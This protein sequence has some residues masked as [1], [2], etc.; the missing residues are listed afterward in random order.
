MALL[1]FLL[2]PPTLNNSSSKISGVFSGSFDAEKSSFSTE[3]SSLTRRKFLCEGMSFNS[4]AAFSNWLAAKISLYCSTGAKEVMAPHDYER[5]CR[6]ARPV[7]GG[8]PAKSCSSC[9]HGRNLLMTILARLG[10]RGRLYGNFGV[11]TPLL[12]ARR[13]GF[14]AKTQSAS[15]E[16]IG[17]SFL[18]EKGT[19]FVELA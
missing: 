1:K 15:M 6:F 11:K 16:Q 10:V 2:R 9:I 5:P 19:Q 3:W 18:R 17:W 8:V 7:T 4:C 14:S 13:A 12:C